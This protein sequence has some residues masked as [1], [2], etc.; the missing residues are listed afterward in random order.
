MSLTRRSALALTGSGITAALAG[1]AVA[2]AQPKGAYA[3]IEAHRDAVIAS[4]A[5]W[6]TLSQLQDAHPEISMAIAKVQYGRM[7][8]SGKDENGNDKWKPLY[9]YDDKEIDAAIDQEMDVKL[10]IWAWGDSPV[11]IQRRADITARVEER[12]QRLK[13]DL[14]EQEAATKAAEDACGITSALVVA[15]AASDVVDKRLDALMSYACRD[16]G[17]VTAIAAY[18]VECD[19]NGI[20]GIESE[21]AFVACVRALAGQA[22]QS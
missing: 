3:L 21:T 16:F 8:D 5:V 1:I 10:R 13:A 14:R 12:R 18:L 4:D 22:V 6:L 17:E 2:A 9:A 7:L 11:A 19:Q 15:R 20:E